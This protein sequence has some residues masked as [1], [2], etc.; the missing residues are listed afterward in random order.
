[1][2]LATTGADPPNPE[3]ESMKL[4]YKLCPGKHWKE[5]VL[6]HLATAAPLPRMLKA[7]AALDHFP[8]DIIKKCK[9]T[10][11]YNWMENYLKFNC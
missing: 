8:P 3:G 4:F 5:G 11:F 10:Y 2:I 1:M 7:H 9:V 6:L